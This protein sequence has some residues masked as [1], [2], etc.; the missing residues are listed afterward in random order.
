MK[1]LDFVKLNENEVIDNLIK[2]NLIDEDDVE[3]IEFVNSGENDEICGVEEMGVD[4]SFDKE[5]LMGWDMEE[6]NI[7][8]LN[9]NDKILFGC[10]YDY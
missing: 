1:V 3:E 7:I 8:E 4:F 6:E 9:I 2:L 5:K 10:F